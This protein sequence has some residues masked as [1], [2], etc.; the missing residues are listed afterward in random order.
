MRTFDPAIEDQ[1][2]SGKLD[3]RDALI[4]ILDEG[5]FGF[6]AGVRGTLTFNVGGIDVDFVG[7]GSLIELDVPESDVQQTQN[8][9]EVSICSKYEVDGVVTEIISTDVL[10]GIE[11]L[12]WYRRPAIVGRLWISEGGQIIDFEQLMRCEIHEVLHEEDDDKGY[13]LKGVLQTV[14]VFRRLVDVKT[15]NTEFQA[16]L[17]PTDRGLEAVSQMATDTVYW[18]RKDPNP[19]EAEDNPRR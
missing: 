9:L 19:I 16:T 4:F 8:S 13:T 15:R 5:T 3:R 2:D 1:L 12:S 10:V 14:E 17:D 18:G 6:V 7:S 11:A